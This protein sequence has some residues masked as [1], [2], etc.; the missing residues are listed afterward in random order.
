MM[1]N[2]FFPDGFQF[3]V[4]KFSA[5]GGPIWRRRFYAP[6]LALKIPAEVAPRVVK[7]LDNAEAVPERK[8]VEA[9]T[10][11]DLSQAKVIVTEFKLPIDSRTWA[12]SEKDLFPVESGKGFWLGFMLDDNDRPG[13]DMQK[14]EVWPASFSTFSIKEDSTWVVFE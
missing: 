2:G 8:L 14:F 5:D 10:G 12:G 1:I 13:V 11:E 3:C 4:G 9:A 6:K 7:V